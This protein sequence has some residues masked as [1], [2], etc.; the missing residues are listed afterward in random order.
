MRVQTFSVMINWG[1]IV[2]TITELFKYMQIAAM[3]YIDK[4]P[5][6]MLYLALPLEVGFGASA[7]VFYFYGN[8]YLVYEFHFGV[9]ICRVSKSDRKTIYITLALV[10]HL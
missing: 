9:C 4:C 10:E 8:L 2:P 5:S 7:V 3:P 1:F 6:N